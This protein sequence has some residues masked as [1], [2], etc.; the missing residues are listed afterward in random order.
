MFPILQPS[1][2]PPQST[3]EASLTI[4][5][6]SWGR[7]KWIPSPGTPEHSPPQQWPWS[8]VRWG[9]QRLQLA[10]QALT[11]GHEP[12]WRGFYLKRLWKVPPIYMVPDASG[13]I[14]YSWSFQKTTDFWT[15][16][17]PSESRWRAEWVQLQPLCELYSKGGTWPPQFALS[18]PEW[19][20]DNPTHFL[21]SSFSLLLQQGL[22]LGWSK[23]NLTS[24]TALQFSAELITASQQPAYHSQPKN[25]LYIRPENF[26][27]HFSPNSSIHHSQM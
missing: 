24:L 21:I 8:A 7:P 1:K 9:H 3:P 27:I 16:S 18:S 13:T 22:R 11:L 19:S 4:T 12:A 2:E 25:S 15:S 6:D 14:T 23:C 26:R 10:L 5:D 20:M 17:Q